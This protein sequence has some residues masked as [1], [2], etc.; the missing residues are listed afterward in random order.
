MKKEIEDMEESSKRE[1]PLLLIRRVDQEAEVEIGDHL[2]M[3]RTEEEIDIIMIIID[4]NSNKEVMKMIEENSIMKIMREEMIDREMIDSEMHINQKDIEVVVSIE[5]NQESL[6]ELKELR[7]MIEVQG[8]KEMIEIEEV[9]EV[10][11][12]IEEI[13]VIEVEE[14]EE[15]L[16]LEVEEVTLEEIGVVL[17]EVIEILRILF[18]ISQ[19]MINKLQLKQQ[20]YLL[21]IC[22][23][24]NKSTSMAIKVLLLIHNQTKVISN[25]VISNMQTL[26]LTK[27]NLLLLSS[28][29]SN[30]NQLLTLI[31]KLL[32]I[33]ECY[34][35]FFSKRYILIFLLLLRESLL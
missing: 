13:E 11:N 8:K 20:S 21:K 10:M 12:H 4:L 16:D 2:D 17:E 31:S 26:L 27:L 25:Q 28:S 30:S 18:P 9:E 1:D 33:N 34:V 7:D 3:N 14:V 5:I 24:I 22:K 23:A 35:I 6:I 29:N 32:V 15:S 19:T